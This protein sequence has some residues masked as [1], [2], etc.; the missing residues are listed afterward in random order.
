MGWGC[1]VCLLL[2]LQKLSYLLCFLHCN[3]S[4]FFYINR[5]AQ[6]IHMP[7]SD[8]KNTASFFQFEI[9]IIRCLS[10]S[11]FGTKTELNIFSGNFF[12]SVNQPIFKQDVSVHFTTVTSCF[13]AFA[14]LCS[15][16][17]LVYIVMDFPLYM[18]LSNAYYFLK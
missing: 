13:H 11:I 4:D 9:K 2:R 10:L 1:F 3:F 6:G 5:H 8:A 17:P 15:K 12:P 7:M 16:L 18:L 14:G